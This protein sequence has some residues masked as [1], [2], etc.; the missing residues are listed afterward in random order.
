M[1]RLILFTLGILTG[2]VGA[3]SLLWPR[4][5]A[6]EASAA[7]HRSPWRS[8]A[9]APDPEPPPGLQS[10]PALA[11]AGG[12]T[13]ALWSDTRDGGTRLW[14]TR[15]GATLPDRLG[16]RAT[17]ASAGELHPAVAAGSDW[18]LAAWES[19][20]GTGTRL[21]AAELP[22]TGVPREVEGTEVTTGSGPVW[23]PAAAVRGEVGILAWED[24]RNAPGDLYFARWDHGPGLRDPGGLALAAG[25]A[26]QRWV[27]IAAG[28]DGFLAVWSS[29]PD[30]VNYT[31]TA[32]PLDPGGEPA[33]PPRAVSDP[34]P[35][36]PNPDVAPLG[37][38]FLVV[39]RAPGN[40][41]SDLVGRFTDP[42]G[43]PGTSGPFS[44]AASS[45]FEYEPRLAAA[46]AGAH[47][48]WME[49]GPAGRALR[50]AWLDMGGVPH[51]AGGLLV[52][53]PLDYV[54]DPA[55]AAGG[56][57]AVLAWRLPTPGDDDDLYALRVADGDSATVPEAALLSVS[58]GAPDLTA[59]GDRG[60]RPALHGE[61]NPFER[62]VRVSGA[63]VVPGEKLDILDIRGRR[64]RVL[65]S[66]SGE[67]G[68]RWDGRLAAGT[69][70]PP[71][72]Y[73][74]RRRENG[75]SVKMLRLP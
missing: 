72:V 9:A 75:G 17:Q 21:I 4:E 50:R 10:Q 15:L 5:Y 67:G 58:T 11:A 73:F 6:G 36:G 51:P 33:G 68:W 39:W 54:A 37:G 62:V 24:E 34:T 60:F 43:S 26:D 13:Y 14:W 20:T 71:G 12:T 30:G 69:E 38:G 52:T 19:W 47:L 63:D 48:A 2:L 3:A 56:G 70:A 32:L 74:A 23:R 31:V 41:G 61:P 18:S 42:A 59:V 25:P 29:A 57:S 16:A 35:G 40:G 66:G 27:R 49:Q 46:P 1:K 22:P 44:I 7:A 65:V 28:D 64:I 45:A 55:L 8:A 53:D